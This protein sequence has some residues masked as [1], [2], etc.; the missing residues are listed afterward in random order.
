MT[1]RLVRPNHLASIWL[2]NRTRVAA[3]F[4]VPDNLACVVAGHRKFTLFPP[5]QLENLYIGPVDFTP[6]G[7]SISLV[8][9]SDPDLDRFPKFE[10]AMRNAYLADMQPGDALFIPSMW[11]HHV[12]SFDNLNVLINY[13][14]RQSPS[15]MG[16]PADV[17]THAFLSLRD[18]PPEQRSAWKG[19]F[20]HYIFDA[21]ETTAEHIPADKRGVLSPLDDMTARK[22]ASR[23]AAQ[24]ESLIDLRQEETEL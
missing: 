17:L 12:E 14:W 19:I 8:D 20:E 21:D 16:T 18:L 13:W 23:A 4:D 5:D 9:F 22:I 1:L 3:H 10:A 24:V 15:F 6:A 11:W 7:Q 2:G